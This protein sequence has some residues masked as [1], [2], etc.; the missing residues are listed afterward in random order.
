MRSILYLTLMSVVSF[1]YGSDTQFEQGQEPS[2]LIE[3]EETSS[4]K[5]RQVY[6]I[7]T[8]DALFK[9]VLSQKSVQQSFFK[10][11]LPGIPIKSIER[12]DEH[13]NPTQSFQHLRNTFAGKD[14][15]EVVN[16]LKKVGN[17]FVHTQEDEADESLIHDKA[18][19]FLTDVISHFDD[20]QSLIPKQEYDG[21]MDFVCQL[22]NGDYALVEMQVVPQ[23]HWD[24]R[25]LAYVAAFYGNQLRKGDSWKDL[26]KV[27]GINILGGG[28]DAL[29]HWVKT[30]E[31]FVRHYKMQEQK[32]TPSRCLN[33][34][35]IIQYSLMNAPQ[36]FNEDELKDWVTFFRDSSTMSES[37][38]DK[39]IKT[40]AVKIAFSFSKI[41][42]LPNN[43]KKKYEEDEARYDKYSEHTQKQI[44]KGRKEGK[45]EGRKKGRK[46]GEE[47]AKID[48]A[49]SMIDDGFKIDIIAKHSR[50]SVKKIEELREDMKKE[51]RVRLREK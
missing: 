39:N 6:G 9:Y 22:N 11:F 42:S 14:V 21:T 37:D 44:E 23:N 49:R 16:S 50:L 29:Q 19:Q 35:E 33:G 45:K 15:A 5:Q 3:L 4:K 10:T 18:T 51:K 17:F 13:M 7:A 8:Y 47:K 34:I 27:I 20:F 30:P 31:Q 32:H 41:A 25:A 12:L 1:V 28:K 38:V 43:V 2:L 36:T 26:K 40:E 48:M 46:E 24:E